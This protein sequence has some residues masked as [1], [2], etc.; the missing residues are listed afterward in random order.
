MHK[1]KNKHL[2][3]LKDQARDEG[4]NATH[5]SSIPLGSIINSSDENLD[6]SLSV[7]MKAPE[8]PMTGTVITQKRDDCQKYPSIDD[9]PKN[10]STITKHVHKKNDVVVK[11]LEKELHE[12]LDSFND[13]IEAGSLSVR[14]LNFVT[15]DLAEEYDHELHNEDLENIGSDTP[16]NCILSPTLKQEKRFDLRLI[17]LLF[18]FILLEFIT[19]ACQSA[20]ITQLALRCQWPLDKNP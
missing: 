14:P 10:Q 12:H 7:S 15:Q 16:E 20:T 8:V 2:P 6:S 3:V 1:I 19:A 11:E 17:I 5:I 4:N 9:L 13:P 18:Y